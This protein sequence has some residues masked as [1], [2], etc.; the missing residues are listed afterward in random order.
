MILVRSFLAL[1][2][3]A[4]TA[5]GQIV[6][7]PATPVA[8][9]LFSIAT[10]PSRP[11]KT[12]DD[13]EVAETLDWSISDG[14]D[15][16]Q[17]ASGK[18]LL[19]TALPGVIHEAKLRITTHRYRSIQVF[20]PDPEFPTDPTK[21]KLQT[22]RDYLGTQVADFATPIE[23][24]WPDGP[25]P[26]PPKPDPPGP[27]PPPPSGKRD[28]VILYESEDQ[29]PSRAILFTSLRASQQG[30]YLKDKGHRLI[31]IDDDT[32]GPNGQLAEVVA[33]YKSLGVPL[34]ALFV[35]DSATGA[36]LVKQPLPDTAGE[37]VE[38]V[39][40]HGG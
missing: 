16:R 6:V 18:T 13:V 25:G 36:V 37:V 30:Q 9:K 4:S 2:L 38:L 7:T 14:V 24:V 28:V 33:K 21:A 26:I 8:G 11:A 10:A 1:L 15:Y 5:A 35:L 29:T 32:V 40:Q 23:V 22:I 31:I 17:S 20:V 12:D 3:L 34:P 39:K 19:A 27:T